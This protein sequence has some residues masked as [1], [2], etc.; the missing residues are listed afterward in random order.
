VQ[1]VEAADELLGRS[2]QA[3]LGHKAKL[4][5]DRFKDF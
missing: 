1:F 3:Y 5:L 2:L 4:A